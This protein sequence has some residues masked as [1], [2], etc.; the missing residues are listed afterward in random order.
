MSVVKIYIKQF[1]CYRKSWWPNGERVVLWLEGLG[2]KTRLG[3]YV[4]FFVF[5]LASLSTHS[6]GTGELSGKREKKLEEG[7]DR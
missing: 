7:F 1:K 5:F 6:M 3:D 2:F 4:V